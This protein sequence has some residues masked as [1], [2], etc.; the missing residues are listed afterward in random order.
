MNLSQLKSE[1]ISV[2]DRGGNVMQLEAAVRVE[3]FLCLKNEAGCRD[4]LFSAV[5]R[6]LQCSKSGVQQC[7]LLS[8]MYELMTAESPWSAKADGEF[9]NAFLE[10]SER[11][12]PEAC[13]SD[14]EMRA[15]LCRVSAYY[16][17][18]QD[19]DFNPNVRGFVES[20]VTAWM[21][22][23]VDNRWRD[24][25]RGVAID[26]LSAIQAWAMANADFRLMAESDAV[27]EAYADDVLR[28]GT[29]GELVR[30]HDVAEASGRLQ[31]LVSQIDYKLSTMH[32]S[33]LDETDSFAAQSVL[34]ESECHSVGSLSAV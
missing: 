22:L 3:L 8:L 24:A 7:R 12:M 4:R 25:S 29:V 6:A 27:V 18:C 28:E 23:L 21:S 2:A 19:I 13:A 26:R 5:R 31:S 14:G 1:L 15:L 20:C 11:W 33:A 10:W 9:V 17:Y 34:L 32:D 30:L 16:L